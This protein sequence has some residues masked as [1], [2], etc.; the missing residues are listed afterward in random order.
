MEEA[1]LEVE[2]HEDRFSGHPDLRPGW[3]AFSGSGDVTG[4]V[5]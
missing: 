2:R 5:V 4:E 1:G 3:T